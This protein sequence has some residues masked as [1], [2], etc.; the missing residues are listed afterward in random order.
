MWIKLSGEY[1]NLDH[2]VR[3]KTSKSF[4]HGEPEWSVDLEGIIKGELTYFT[5]YRGVDAEIVMHALEIASRLE[6][7]PTDAVN[8]PSRGTV[9]D[10]K[11]M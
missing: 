2:I 6:P 5:R 7:A 9:H 4:K 8:A 3:I 11:I 1:L 10:V